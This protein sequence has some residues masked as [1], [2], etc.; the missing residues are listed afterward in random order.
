MHVFFPYNY[1]YYILHRDFTVL[2]PHEEA[3]SAS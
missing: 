3:R 1:N 2:N